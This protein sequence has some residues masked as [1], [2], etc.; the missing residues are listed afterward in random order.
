MSELREQYDDADTLSAKL[1]SSLGRSAPRSPT[2]AL[3]PEAVPPPPHRSRAVRHP[4]VVFLNF[5]LTVVIVGAVLG[6]GAFFVAQSQFDSPGGLAQAQTF[7][8]AEQTGL[9][10]IA[11]KLQQEGIIPSRWLFVAGVMLNQQQ[12][13]LKAGE[14]LIPANASMKDIMDTMVSGRGIL[15]AVT[16]PEGLTSRQIVERLLADEVLVG[17]ITEIPPEGTLLP[18]TYRFTRG[19]TRVDLIDRMRRD[20]DTALAGVWRNRAPDLPVSTPE[21]LVILASVV[22]KETALADE[23]TRVAAVFI[24]RLRQN[25][26]LQ[27]DPTVIYGMFKD[28]GRPPGFVLSR[29]DLDNPTPYNTYRNDGLPPG[30]IANPGRASLEAIA[31]PSRTRDLFF[32]ADGTGG[33]VFAETY[34]EHLRNVARWREF[35]SEAAAVAAAET[36]APVAPAPEAGAAETLALPGGI[37]APS[38][39]PPAAPPL[40][41]SPSLPAIGGGDAP[42]ALQPQLRP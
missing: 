26:R 13:N 34:D 40:A 32:V 35:N 42:L 4:V 36:L 16:I 12:G 3:R 37:F 23:R 20:R 41:L 28:T 10:A 22:E 29:A 9:G 25:M 21:E 7:T 18:E 19:D 6:G 30:P 11:D 24:N 15:Y 1:T 8:V 5:L 39:P 33:H 31:N 14:Y 2:E 27:S 17:D 38:S